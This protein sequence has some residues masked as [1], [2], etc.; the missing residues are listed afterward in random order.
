MKTL[1]IRR[2]SLRK[3]N[4]GSQLS[5]AGV[6]Y[7]RKLGATMGPFQRVVTTVV[8]RTRETAIA[9]GFAVDYELV[10]LV[11][12]DAV[13][14]EAEA[15]GW[16]KS[17]QPF[18]ALA[19]VIAMQGPTW[20]YAHAMAAS[21][22]DLLTP[23]PDGAAALIIGHSGELEAALVAC[24]PQADYAAWG[25]PFQPCEGARLVFAG[26]PERFTTVELLRL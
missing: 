15:T 12:D 25:E 3:H 20:R 17:P 4:G 22:R 5:Q 18:A 24:F 8:P 1:E 16:W 7:A 9:M 11:S 26:E 19:A 21:W 23:L 14:A 13:Y 6:E 10:T 2:H